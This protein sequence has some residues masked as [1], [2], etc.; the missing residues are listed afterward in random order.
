MEQPQIGCKSWGWFVAVKFTASNVPQNLWPILKDSPLMIS[1]RILH[2]SVA[3]GKKSPENRI[4]WVRVRP[5]LRE[6]ETRHKFNGFVC[7]RQS[8]SSRE[9]SPTGNRFFIPTPSV[10]KAASTL[11]GTDY[12]REIHKSLSHFDISYLWLTS[13]YYRGMYLALDRF[14]SLGMRIKGLCESSQR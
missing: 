8:Q 11:A 3:A 5:P 13:L 6:R 14:A 7:F 1:I 10:P 9:V 4:P 2:E 12:K